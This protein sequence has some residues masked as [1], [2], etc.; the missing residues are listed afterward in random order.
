MGVVMCSRCDALIDLDYNVE[1]I[2]YVNEKE[3]CIN[4]ASEEE[5]DT[6]EEEYYGKSA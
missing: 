3:V 2:I 4:C 1:N 5:I 6:W